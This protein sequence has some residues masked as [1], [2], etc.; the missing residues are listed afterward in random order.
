M[1]AWLFAAA[2]SVAAANA[3]APAAWAEGPRASSE[4]NWPA[5]SE[6]YPE[7]GYPAAVAQ[8]AQAPA[9]APHY[10]WEEGYDHG[11]KWH[12]HWSLVP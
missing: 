4:H 11:G 9:A 8:P 6:T 10:V 7:T 1:K 2:V 3:F 5:M 12:G